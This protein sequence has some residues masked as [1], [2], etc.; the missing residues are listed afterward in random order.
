MDIGRFGPAYASP[1]YTLARTTENYQTYY[2]IP[3]PGLER[4]S[5]RPLRIS[6]VYPWH[7]TRRAVFGEKAGWERVNYYASN[8]DPASETL[9]PDGWAGRDWS[10]ATVV[11]HRATR[12]AAGL[13]DETCFAKLSVRGRDAAA[14][15]QHTCDNDVAREVGAITYTQA[16]NPR[17]G[18][19]SDFTVTRLGDEDFLVVTGTAYGTHDL[20]WLRK[21]ARLGGYD[22]TLA[23]V[24]GA[25]ATFALWG[26]TARTILGALTP[27]DVSDE[28]F[29]FMTSQ[30]ITVADVPVRAL[31]VTF[32]GEHGWELYVSTEYAARALEPP[33]RSRGA[34]GLVPCGY[35]AIESLRLEMGYRVWSHRPDAGDDAE[36]GRT[37]VLCEARQA[38]WFRRARRACVAARKAGLSRRLSLLVLDDP[39]AVVLGS[40]PVRVADDV[41]GRVT[42]GGFGFT[43]E[44]S[45]AYAYLP[46]DL[47]KPGTRA[48][49]N[50]FGRHV[51]ATVTDV[52]TLLSSP[53]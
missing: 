8:E 23:D 45:L 29:P 1:S 46:V 28:G 11:E 6:P 30:Q 47:S 31:R 42:S 9:R 43:C 53:R 25:Y 33:G 13:F 49:I 15:L 14:F 41:V 17:G 44:Q 32:T 21:Q 51:P 52:R 26:P 39:R 36:R 37:G 16:L 35:R 18:I 20:A 24:T 22:V 50:L 19:E 7:E 40:E 2:D 4:L 3:Y 12:H 48:L 38:G 5:G 10:T 27:A 34:H